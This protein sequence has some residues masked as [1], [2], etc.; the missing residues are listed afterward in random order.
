[1]PL[2]GKTD[3][4]A[5]APKYVARIAYF[6]ATSANV[7]ATANTISLVNSNTGFS[8]GDEVVYSVQDGGAI[9]GMTDGT[10]YYVRPTAAGVITLYDTY[11]H[12]IA[13]GSTTG[14]VDIS[15]AGTGVNSLQRTG[16]ANASGYEHIYNGEGIYF[17]DRT[18]AQQP[19]ARAK[20]FRGPGWW[21][22][23]SYVD[24]SSITRYRAECLVAIS[25][26]PA[27]SGDAADDTILPDGTITVVTPSNVTVVDAANTSFTSSATSSPS[28]TMTYLWQ[29]STD[30]G[31][32]WNDLSNGGVYSNVA[33]TTLGLT[34]PTYAYNGY[35]Y[36]LS[37]AATG[38][39]K[40]Y[41]AAA[42]LTVTPVTI[43]ISVFASTPSP[44]SVTHPATV[45]FSTTAATT[46]SGRTLTYT[47]QKSTDSGAHW[48]TIGGATSA[49]YTTPATVTGD[50]GTEYRVVVSR[51]GATS[52]T[53]SPITITVS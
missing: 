4:L 33:T 30:G 45:A 52:A 44:A 47:W 2:W 27:T 20:G 8:L 11:D 36:R 35:K 41:S 10:T 40:V 31:D 48:S 7:N 39:T 23:K 24:S 28:T 37:V 15:S 32:T 38:Y 43:A 21:L 50:N 18:E 14:I 13:T 19:E 17:V 3:N 26:V 49:T 12:A 5:G 22:W 29:V 46:P 34:A 6:T 51:A 16:A 1:M 42:T 9:G 25:V 53:S